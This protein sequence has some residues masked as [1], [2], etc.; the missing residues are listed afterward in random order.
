MS[1]LLVCLNAVA[2]I[3]IIMALGCLARHLGAIS[4]SDVPKLNK[5]LFRY[6]MPVMLFYNIYSSD[7]STAVQP[8]LLGFTALCVLVE[9]FLCLGFVLLTEK[10]PAKR[11]VKIQGLYR[12]NFVIIGLPLASALVSGADVGPVVVL[13]AVVVPMYNVLAVIIL[14]IFNGTKPNIGHLLLDII[15]NP[16]ILGTVFGM[17]FLLLGIELPEVLLSAVRQ[18]GTATNPMMLFLLGAF[19]QWGGVHKYIKDLVQVCLGRLVIVPGVFLTLAYLAGVRG[20]E[21]AGMIAIFGSATA[22]ASF[23]M[24]QQMG[25]DDE[26]AG[27]IVV[28]TSALCCFTMFGWSL[29]F[30]TLGAF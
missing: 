20:I 22:I 9:F 24:V 10:D 19:F 28:A 12:S 8:K 18:I 5:V 16:L 1:N 4:R 2:P 6:F 26:L 7:L 17:G 23:T 27:D 14:E 30:R 15:K 13:I 11:G 21:F 25:G 29:L 3:F